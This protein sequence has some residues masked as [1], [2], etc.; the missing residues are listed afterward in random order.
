MAMPA[1]RV[2]E[3]SD[4]PLQGNTSDNTPQDIKKSLCP[5]DQDT[6]RASSIIVPYLLENAAEFRHLAE[7][8]QKVDRSGAE[9][10]AEFQN[11]NAD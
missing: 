6:R 2:K 7:L 9:T 1:S 5:A 11:D 3:T 10:R 4:V 8:R